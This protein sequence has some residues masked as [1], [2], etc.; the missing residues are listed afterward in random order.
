[1]TL[2]QLWQNTLQWGALFLLFVGV[3]LF[4]AGKLVSGEIARQ[5][6]ATA[7]SAQATAHKDAMDAFQAR[8]DEMQATW[9]ERYQDVVK[10]RDYFR[11]LATT[12]AQQAEQG[13]SAAE[14][15]SGAQPTTLRRL[16]G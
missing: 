3:V 5:A 4:Y 8:Y 14:V 2:D 7:V 10:D 11:A 12:L 1:M 13:I 16:G 9:R 15:L 6:Q